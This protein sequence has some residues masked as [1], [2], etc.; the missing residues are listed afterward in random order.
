MKCPKWVGPA[1]DIW[2]GSSSARVDI[3]ADYLH[4]IF[5]A[6]DDVKGLIQP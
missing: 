2:G 3:K 6:R 4:F 1:E 5:V